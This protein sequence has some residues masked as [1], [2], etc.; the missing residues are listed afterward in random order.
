MLL[1]LQLL[2]ALSL[3]I[4]TDGYYLSIVDDCIGGS[5]P[6]LTDVEF[7]R[8]YYFNKDLLIQ[9]N[10]TVGKFVGFGQFGELNAENW[11]NSTYVTGM[12]AELDRYCRP[13]LRNDY[14]AI[15][16]KT[17][18][19]KVKLRSA[20]KA[21]GR[22]AMLMCSAYNFYPPFIDVYWLRDGEKVTTGT[23][24]TG[25]MADG[26]WYYQ[27]HSH[28]EYKP[29]SRKKISCVVEHASSKEPIITDWDDSLSQAERDKT[30]VGA[31]GLVLG[32]IFLAGGFFYYKRKTLCRWR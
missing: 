10:S 2:L 11:N 6:D 13:N 23:V 20:P 4:R 9:F 17:V 29:K 26:D 28:L 8:S 3:T 31:A 5:L 30:A 12:Q 18:K 19:P 15:L 25:E 27:V 7:L 1:T 24:S 14:S 22:P 32:I 21:S 16:N